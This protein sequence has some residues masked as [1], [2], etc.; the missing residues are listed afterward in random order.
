VINQLCE[1]I[2][3]VRYKFGWVFKKI[4]LDLEDN[5]PP[6]DIPSISGPNRGSSE[7]EYEYIISTNDFDND[8]IYYY[9]DW[10]DG[11]TSGWFGPHQLGEEISVEHTWSEQGTYNI[12]L[13]AKDSD[14]RNGEI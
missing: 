2:S 7:T 6:P 3:I 8:E 11:T 13:K 1:Q 14:V 9:I 5:T 12:R 10:D 4:F